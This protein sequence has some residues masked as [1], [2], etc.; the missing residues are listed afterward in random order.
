MTKS[1][2][3][4]FRLLQVQSQIKAPKSQYNNFGKYKYRNC[5]DILEALKP[6]L[7]EHNLLVIIND[8]LVEFNGKNFLKATVNVYDCLSEWAISTSSFA[9]LPDSK[10]GM[11]PSQVTGATSSYARKYAL[12]A[13]FCIDDTKDSDTT[14]NGEFKKN[15]SLPFPSKT[16]VKTMASENNKSTVEKMLAQFNILGVTKDVIESKIDLESISDLEIKKLRNAYM[17]VKN[18]ENILELL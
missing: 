7:I 5:E 9:E 18:G 3:G 1:N 8:D 13:M 11:D 2:S 17:K 14:N 6:V 10:K 16:P 15:E 12:N 4:L